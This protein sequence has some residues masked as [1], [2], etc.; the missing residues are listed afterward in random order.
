MHAAMRAG[1]IQP[2]REGKQPLFFLFWHP[3]LGEDRTNI[4]PGTGVVLLVV[5]QSLIIEEVGMNGRLREANL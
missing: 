4:R 3:A 1:P 5:D 2:R